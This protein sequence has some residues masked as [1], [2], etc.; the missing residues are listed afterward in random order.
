MVWDRIRSGLHRISA[1]VSPSRS[2]FALTFGWNAL[3]AHQMLLYPFPTVRLLSHIRPVTFLSGELAQWIGGQRL[4]LAILALQS[5]FSPQRARSQYNSFVFAF[6]GATQTIVGL[7]CVG[8][9]RWYSGRLLVFLLVEAS[10]AG[11][12]LLHYLDTGSS[13]RDR[14]K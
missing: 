3:L 8:R 7:V 11:A 13:H 12:H 10:L 14:D 5:L 2:L 9:G 1:S 6:L 4:G